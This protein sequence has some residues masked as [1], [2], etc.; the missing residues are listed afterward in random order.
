MNVSFYIARRYL[1]SASKSTAINVINR[2]AAVGIVAGGAALFVA[3]SVFSGLIDF[4]LSFSN[5]ADP[6]LKAVV[7]QGKSIQITPEQKRSLTQLP[8]VNKWSAVVEERALFTYNGKE[9]VAVLKGVDGNFTAVTGLQKSIYAGEWFLQNSGQV[10]VGSGLAQNL[11]IGLLDY[12]N[13]FEVL[14]PRAGGAEV[15]AVSDAFHQTV[16]YPS[17]FFSVSEELDANYVFCDIRL[18][19]QLLEYQPNEYSAIEFAVSSSDE[20][21]QTQQAIGQILGTKVEVKNRAQLND[22]LYKM[23]NTE[24][25]VVY[26]FFTLVLIIVMFNLIGALIMMIIEK[27][28]NLQTLLNMGMSVKQLRRIFLLQGSLL[29]VVGGILGIG[30]GAVLVYLQQ[31]FSLVMIT[32]TLAYP[33][34]FEIKNVV[35]VFV[36][37]TTLGFFASMLASNRV[38]ARFLSEK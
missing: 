12:N 11:S 29:C 17:G 22:A 36:T 38:S 3:L 10:V 19:Q 20:V 28:S 2:I 24:N 5:A 13:V 23:L 25:L 1:R 27:K 16:L 33:I 34:V 14:M 4:S 31:Q 6:D 35:I 8:N 15:N 9:Q 37:I 21:D 32:P 18:A 7:V 26:L 30:I